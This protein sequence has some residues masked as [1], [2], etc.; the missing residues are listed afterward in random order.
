VKEKM[1][2]QNARGRVSRIE[3]EIDERAREREREHKLL[4]PMESIIN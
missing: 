3:R 1:K 4:S 2:R